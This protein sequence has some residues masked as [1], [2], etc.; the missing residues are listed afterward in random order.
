MTMPSP[1]GGDF[2]G[3]GSSTR[4]HFGVAES[5]LARFAPRRL[6]TAYKAGDTVY[7][8]GARADHVYEVARGMIRTVGLTNDGRRVVHGFAPSGEVFGVERGEAHACS[9]EAVC[10]C[11]VIECQRVRIERLAL[12][13]AAAASQLWSWL[14]LG[15]EQARDRLA[16]ARG[17]AIKR[18]AR[19]LLAMAD[20]L[21]VASRLDLPMSRYDIA[22]YLGLSSETVSRTLTLLRE[23]GAI[24]T[25]G[26]AILLLRPE[27]LRRV[28]Q[29]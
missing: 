10:D 15:A 14:L 4:V 11:L 27:I 18:V 3:E 24:A 2:R 16:L 21:R 22:D 17:S 29:A 1:A 26:R 28:D 13:D 20:Q 9:A 12:T 19:F 6:P 8:E 5:S 25:E 23:R 7:S